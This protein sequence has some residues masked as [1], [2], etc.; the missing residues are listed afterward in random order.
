MT[1]KGMVN[2]RIEGERECNPGMLYG[3]RNIEIVKRK[4]MLRIY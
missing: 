2:S 3:S 1:L 4:R